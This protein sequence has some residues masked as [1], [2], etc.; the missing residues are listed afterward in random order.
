MQDVTFENN[1][2]YGQPAGF[3][4]VAIQQASIVDGPAAVA[5]A[6]PKVQVWP[7]PAGPATQAESISNSSNF[8]RGFLDPGGPLAAI[9]AVRLTWL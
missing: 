7:W 9:Q 2:V 1:L 3:Q 6:S 8:A 4:E 5:Y